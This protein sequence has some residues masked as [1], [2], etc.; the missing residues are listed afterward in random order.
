MTQ[1]PTA[2]PRHFLDIA[3]VSPDDLRL[4]IED[5]ARRKSLLP[6]GDKPLAGNQ[7]HGVAHA[8]E[9]DG[10]VHLVGRRLHFRFFLKIAN[11]FQERSEC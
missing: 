7:P 6:A 5:A 2:S 4:I 3:A 9:T 11:R 10:E 1:N 8:T